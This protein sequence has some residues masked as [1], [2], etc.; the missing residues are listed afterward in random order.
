MRE[1]G[2]VP[3]EVR[4]ETQLTDGQ[5]PCHAPSAWLSVCAETQLMDG[6]PPRLVPSAWFPALPGFPSAKSS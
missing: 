3:A 1:K 6:Q 4:A 5:P 2:P